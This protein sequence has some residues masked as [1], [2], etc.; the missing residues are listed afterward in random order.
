MAPLAIGTQTVASVNRPAAFC[1]I[2]AFKPSSRSLSTFGIT[3]LAPSYD[4]PGLLGWS[5]DD[6]VFAFEAIEPAFM[7][8][9]ATA[10]AARAVPRLGVPMDPHL[11]HMTDAMQTAFERTLADLDRAGHRID[12]FASPID[13]ARLFE[14]QRNTML[15]EAG[16]ALAM[17]QAE[18]PGKV[19][20]KLLEAIGLGLAI[21]ESQYLDERGEIDQMRARFVQASQELDVFVWPATPGPAP[22]SLAWTGDPRFIS[23]WTAIGGPIVSMPAGKVASGLPLGVSL[24]AKPG[25]DKAMCRWARALAVAAERHE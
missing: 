12:R 8:A 22:E 3:P 20:A 7:A 10:P 9:E 5:V 4:T 24:C 15:Y 23:P 2:A 11:S 25:A 18:P 1:G 17:L 6:A 16:R 19:G 21:P 14:I 13:F